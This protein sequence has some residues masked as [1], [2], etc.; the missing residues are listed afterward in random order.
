MIFEWFFMNLFTYLFFEIES[1]SYI[2]IVVETNLIQHSR[3]PITFLM[4]FLFIF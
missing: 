1:N 3:N 2:R 4:I